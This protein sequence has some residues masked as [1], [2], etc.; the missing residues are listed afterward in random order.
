MKAQVK[1]SPTIIV[2]IEA[3]KQKDLFKAIASAHEVFGEKQCGLCES[4]HIVPVWRTSTKVT[5]KKVETF[6]YA[7]Y[8]CKDC[9]ARFSLGVINDQTGTL[10]PIRKLLPNGQP[11]SKSTK[12]LAVHGKHNGWSKYNGK[13]EDE[14]EDPTQ[15]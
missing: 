13:L 7:E 12:H 6:E 11:Y 1:V 8:H 9:R 14:G 3:E 5:G 10:F 4:T 2:D 15:E